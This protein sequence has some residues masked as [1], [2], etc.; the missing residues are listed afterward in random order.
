MMPKDIIEI[1]FGVI[2]PKS[3]F[4][5]KGNKNKAE[6]KKILMLF[7]AISKFSYNW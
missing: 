5:H 3:Y 1:K 2:I 7:T 6:I 4:F